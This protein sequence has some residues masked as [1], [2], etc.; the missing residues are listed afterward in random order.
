MLALNSSSGQDPEFAPELYEFLFPEWT[1]EGS[2]LRKASVAAARV[3]RCA[4]KSGHDRKYRAET[5]MKIVTSFRPAISQA[6]AAEFSAAGAAL[7]VRGEVTRLGHDPTRAAAILRLSFDG[8]ISKYAP[9]T[10]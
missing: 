10:Q 2:R 6:A 3:S 1:S 9:Q 5:G 8:I 7:S 4:T